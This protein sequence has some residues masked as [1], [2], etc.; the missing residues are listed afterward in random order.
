MLA[1]TDVEVSIVLLRGYTLSRRFEH[2]TLVDFHTG[3]HPRGRAQR[4]PEED[5]VRRLQRGPG[6]AAAM[7]VFSCVSRGVLGTPRRSSAGNSASIKTLACILHDIAVRLPA[8]VELHRAGWSVSGLPR[9][10]YL[11]FQPPSLREG[12]FKALHPASR[13]AREKQPRRSVVA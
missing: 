2:L 6:G 7:I 1:V 3:Q 13:E 9:S 12:D 8:C 4:R 5:N 10:L 11:L